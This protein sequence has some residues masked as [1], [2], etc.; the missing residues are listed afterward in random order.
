MKSLVVFYSLTGNTS[1]V[2]SKIAALL[3]ADIERILE[4]TP[5]QGGWGYFKAAL[6]SLTGH[7][8][9][10]QQ[11]KITP[12]GY[13]LVIVAGPIWTGRIAPP[14]QT[15][16]HQF[17]KDFRH[18]AF[19]VTRNAS[20]PAKGFAHMEALSGTE[21]AATLALTAKEIAAGHY[22]RPVRDFVKT[23]KEALA[24]RRQDVA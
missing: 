22:D 17:R 21:P 11:P 13:D 7:K 15:F 24:I 5:Y 19:C 8:V 9:A 10:I 16:L 12:H 4:K 1:L 14:V 6:H 2:A 3:D 18:I 20:S 23:L